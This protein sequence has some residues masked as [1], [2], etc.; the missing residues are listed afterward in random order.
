MSPAVRQ[1]YPQKAPPPESFDAAAAI[2][3]AVE[4][5][6]SGQVDQAILLLDSA[7]NSSAEPNMGALIA[8]G[9]ARALKRDLKGSSPNSLC[10]P[11]PAN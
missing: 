9:T 8:R 4:H 6:N 2:G 7:I 1:T 3:I 5:I 11:I 10:E